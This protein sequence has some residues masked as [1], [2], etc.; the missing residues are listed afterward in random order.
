[1]GLVTASHQIFPRLHTHNQN[2]CHTHFRSVRIY[3][4]PLDFYFLRRHPMRFNGM[5]EA[6]YFSLWSC[7]C[8]GFTECIM[9][10]VEMGLPGTG[11]QARAG[12]KTRRNLCHRQLDPTGVVREKLTI[13]WVRI[14]GF[15]QVHCDLPAM[16]LRKER[17]WSF[18][19]QADPHF[20]RLTQWSRTTRIQP[21]TTTI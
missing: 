21:P 16:A 20:H 6:F 12:A 18:H 10:R 8:L 2:K 9:P 4:D 13:T 3:L 17:I 11:W 7:R 1:M 5:C 19:D 14:L 15:M